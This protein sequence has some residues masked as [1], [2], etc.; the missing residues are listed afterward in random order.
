[1][2]YTQVG[3]GSKG[4]LQPELLQLYL[5]AFLGLLFPLA[6]FLVFFLVGDARAA[7]LKLSLRAKRPAF[8]KVVAQVDNGMRNVEAP[9]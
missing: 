6:A 5:A 3:P 2:S 4:L 8:A 1:M 9:V 7:V